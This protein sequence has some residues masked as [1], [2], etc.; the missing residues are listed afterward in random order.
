MNENVSLQTENTQVLSRIKEKIPVQIHCNET[1]KFQ[2]QRKNFKNQR[3]STDYLQ[4]NNYYADSHKA[5]SNNKGRKT[6]N[7][8]K[9]LKYVNV[10]FYT[11]GTFSKRENR[12]KTFLKKAKRQHLALTCPS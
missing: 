3:K 1:T 2:R 10:E 8:H 4:R 12:I 11:P 6:E 9:M 7:I 5:L